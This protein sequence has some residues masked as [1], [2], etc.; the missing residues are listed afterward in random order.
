[1]KVFN[2]SIDNVPR[3]IKNI[4]V[5]DDVTL[6]AG[7]K[8]QMYKFWKDAK[9]KYPDKKFFLLVL[10]SSDK[11]YKY[12]TNLGVEVIS[13]I[14]LDGRDKCFSKKS[15]IFSPFSGKFVAE[16]KKFAEH[17]GKK[18]GVTD[19]LGYNNSEFNF[20]FYYNTPDNTLPIFWG[21]INDWHPIVKRYHKNYSES[22]FNTKHERFI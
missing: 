16:A 6:S 2:F 14:T 19:P 13:A 3:D 4:I 22:T 20:G 7:K 12:L 18:I 21:Q 10:I 9:R 15:Q 11:S 17:Y 8:G 1:M 5:I